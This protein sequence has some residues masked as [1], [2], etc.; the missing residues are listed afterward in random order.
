MLLLIVLLFLWNVAGP[1]GFVRFY[2]LN[3]ER[4]G[5]QAATMCQAERNSHL[6]KEL[7]KLKTDPAVQERYVRSKLYWVRDGEILYRFK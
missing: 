3:K 4:K 2:L 1:Y 5:L 7:E 6:K